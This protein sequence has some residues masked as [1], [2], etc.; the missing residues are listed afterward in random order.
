MLVVELSFVFMVGTKRVGGSVLAPVL[1]SAERREATIKVWCKMAVKLVD[2]DVL[3]KYLIFMMNLT[4][5]AGS[6]IAGVNINVPLG[7]NA[8]IGPQRVVATC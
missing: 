6:W 1:S 8:L 5:T 2:L 7:T 4:F 3:Y